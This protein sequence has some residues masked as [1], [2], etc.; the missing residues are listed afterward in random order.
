VTSY[1]EHKAEGGTEAFG[2]AVKL[3]E[4]E[5]ATDDNQPKTDEENPV[6]RYKTE[7]ERADATLAELDAFDKKYGRSS[8]AREATLFRAGVLFDQGRFDDAGKAFAKAAAGEGG[9]P[10]S[11]LAKE[12][13]GLVAE[14]QNK[15]DD[16]L[17]VYQE[18]EP[19]TGDFFRDRALWD[20]ARVLQKKGDKKG[21]AAKLKELTEKV[22]QSPLK[23]SAQNLMASLEAQ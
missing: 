19:K 22:P 12:G 8:T 7:K 3:Y 6:P 1:L 9:A 10:L 4:A 13:V 15:L 23:D 2:R 16:A 14:Q 5:L 11:L 20:Q 18:L 17:K 21:A